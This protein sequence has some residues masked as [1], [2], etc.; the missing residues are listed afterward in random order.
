M[1]NGLLVSSLTVALL[2]AACGKAGDAPVAAGSAP[3]QEKPAVDA[4][5]PVAADV[6]GVDTAPIAAAP[7]AEAA[8]AAAASSQPLPAKFT[9]DIFVPAGYVVLNA[10]DMSGSAMVDL[11]VP[12]TPD[13]V[14]V[15]V[16]SAMAEK[17]WSRLAEVD[18]DKAKQ[19]SFGDESASVFYTIFTNKAGK[20]QVSMSVAPR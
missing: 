9:P 7:I 3:V 5:A 6:P 4:T 16:Q 11:E 15:Q 10:L 17:G 12:G 8:P 14:F 19:V 2:L 20:T 18:G 13:E 1:R